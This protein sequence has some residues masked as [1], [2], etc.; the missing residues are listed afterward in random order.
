MYGVTFGHL[1]WLGLRADAHYSKFD[2]SFGSGSYKAF[3]ISRNFSDNLR[4]EVLAGTQNF[5]S[6][7]T[8]NNR[9]RFVTANVET[10][11]GP[12]YFIQGGFTTDRGQMSYDQW[13]FTIGYR[14]DSKERR[15]E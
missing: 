2:S 6:S 5:A 3:S 10:N 4:L 12:H 1:P 13:M 8:T 11:L 14:F 15:H 9:S 7:F